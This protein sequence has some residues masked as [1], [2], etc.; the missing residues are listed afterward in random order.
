MQYHVRKF[1]ILPLESNIFSH[2]KLAVVI[3]DHERRAKYLLNAFLNPNAIL[4]NLFYFLVS[5]SH[6]LHIYAGNGN[7]QGIIDLLRKGIYNYVDKTF[8]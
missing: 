7:V 3:P 4:F 5:E 6:A 8:Y 1:R 2:K